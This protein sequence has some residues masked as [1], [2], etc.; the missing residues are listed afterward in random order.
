MENSKLQKK[1]R[2]QGE[3]GKKKGFLSWRSFLWKRASKELENL[4]HL[5]IS[6]KIYYSSSKFWKMPPN[7]SKLA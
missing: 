1:K 7:M 4:L 6:K 5:L 2:Q 3:K